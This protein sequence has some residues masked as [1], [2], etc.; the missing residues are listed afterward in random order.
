MQITQHRSKA[1]GLADL[2]LP[3]ALIEDGILL[4]QDGSL[5]AGWSYRGPDMHSAT[6]AEMHALTM[7]LNSILRLGSGW[8]LNAD[9][10]RSRAPGYPE[11]GAFPHAVTR[12]IDDERRQQFMDEGS[13][14]ESDYFLTLTYLPPIETEEKIKGW[15]FEGQN[16]KGSGAAHQILE[17]FKARVEMFENVFSALFRIERLKRLEFTDD[18]GF[19]QVQDRLLRYLRRCVA[20][21]DHP[22]ALPDVP[23]YLNELLAT[24]DFCA[25]IEPR[26]GLKHVRVIALDGFPKS[27]FP[28]ILGEIDSLPM[29][30]RWSTRAVLLDPEEARGLLDKTRKK[31]RSRIRGF[32]DQ[33]FKTHNGAINI[34]AQSMAEDAE[35]AMGVAA[36]G[37]VQFAQYSSN[38]I[39]LDE[40]LDR[41]HENTRLVMKKIQ[42]LGFA[43]RLETINA[44]DAWRGTIPGDGYRNVRRV[45]LH[46]LNLA[47]LL[48]ITSVWAGLRENPSR[49]MPKKS[50]PLL[51]AATTGATP[52]RVNLHVSDL[53]HTLMCGPSGA[54]KSTALGLIAAQWFRYPRAQVFAFDKGYSLFVLTKAA[55]GEF[56]DLAG[57]KTELAFCPLRE[58]D[59]DADLTWAVT[60]LDDLCSLN[61]LTVTP[62]HRNAITQALLQLRLSPSRTLTELSANVQDLEVREALQF[63]TLSGPLG[64]LLD[65]DEDVLSSGRFL[66]FETENLLQL[67]DKAVIPVLLY[68]FRRIE[69]R[70]DGSPTLVS[71]DEAWAYLRN[72][73]F[74][75]RLRDWLKTLRRMN[76]IVLL[77]TQNLSDICNSEISDVILEMCPTKIL[78]PNGEAKN[79][80]SKEFYDRVGLNSRELDILQTSIPKQH[81]YVISPLG[82]RLISLG[83]HNVALSF[84]GVNG[85]EERQLVEDLLNEFPDSWQSEWLRI[86]A[87]AL[88]DERLDGWADYYVKLQKEFEG[89]YQCARA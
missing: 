4:Q 62:K 33:V 40:D 35:Q 82:R 73:V 13:H 80:A 54:G 11:E 56:Y 44:V 74:R 51:F 18:H 38:I 32:K 22:F 42:N 10:I 12:V 39:C 36:S 60:W 46:T 25:G 65:A 89:S 72:D 48:P 1:R 58:I 87:S 75:E 28:G 30:Y 61:G 3:F 9:L 68:L 50:P 24:Q 27:S 8:M 79:P 77:S 14:Y 15:M 81:Y 45:L 69:K 37:D 41:L 23:V 49:L 88:K 26:V 67:D 31:W 21:E 66:T 57:E 20:G 52:F 59:S 63:Y 47:D 43:C 86:R 19:P 6:H 29:E 34:Y 64:Q 17:R 16:G 83:I 78:L 70:L 84:V 71:L 7:R 85:R 53:G 2:L 55:G 5:L 76:G